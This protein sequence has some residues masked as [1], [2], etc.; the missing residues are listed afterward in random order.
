MPTTE[1]PTTRPVSRFTVAVPTTDHMLVKSVFPEHGAV[2]KFM[3]A[4]FSKTAERLRNAD[5]TSYT[6]RDTL[7][8]DALEDLLTIKLALS[9]VLPEHFPPPPKA[10]AS[11][12]QRRSKKEKGTA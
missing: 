7:T 2:T 10:K 3:I 1:Q 11:P 6:D 12:R 9:D 4:L 5:I 8:R